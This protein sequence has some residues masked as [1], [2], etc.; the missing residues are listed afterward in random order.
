MSF[1]DTGI[2]GSTGGTTVCCAG[3]CNRCGGSGCG[4]LDVKILKDSHDLQIRTCQIVLREVVQN[5]ALVRLKI[6]E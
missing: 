5:V 4:A 6:L 3:S 2:L 1:C